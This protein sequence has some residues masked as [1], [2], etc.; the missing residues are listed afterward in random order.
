MTILSYCADVL[1]ERGPL[2]V[3]ELA[4]GAA[5]AGVTLSQNPEASIRSAISSRPGHVV[6]IDDVCWTVRSLLTGRVLTHRLTDEE[7]AGAKIYPGA[8]LAALSAIVS[9]DLPLCVGGQV[10][11]SR[12]GYSCWQG[13]VGWLA[14]F[15]EGEVAGFRLASEGLAVERAHIDEAALARG[16]VLAAGLGRLRPASWYDASVA[17]KPLLRLLAA[18]ADLLRLP[19]PPLVEAVPALRDMAEQETAR[20]A[21]GPAL[22]LLGEPYGEAACSR[23]HLSSFVETTLREVAEQAGCRPGELADAL[24]GSALNPVV[25][26]PPLDAAPGGTR[27][28]GLRSLPGELSS[29]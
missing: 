19:A 11:A 20:R 18:D 5:E 10:T 3:A 15:A 8:D 24:L 29:R 22:H 1:S 21:D 7:I 9:L 14:A 26:L 27:L 16:E 13:P 6:V 12:Y 28:G 23:C 25:L 17:T 4:R 2:P